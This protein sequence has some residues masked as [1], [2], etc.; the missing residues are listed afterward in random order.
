MELFFLK[1]GGGAFLNN[2]ATVTN[3]LYCKFRIHMHVCW[4]QYEV[5]ENRAFDV[6]YATQ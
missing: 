4:R 6:S 5:V 1:A 3:Y 2:V